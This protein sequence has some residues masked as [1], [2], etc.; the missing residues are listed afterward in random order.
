[1]VS[2]QE[3]CGSVFWITGLSNA[4]KSSIAIHLQKK[5]IAANRECILLDGDVIRHL[6]GSDLGYDNIYFPSER[7]KYKF[8][9]GEENNIGKAG[10]NTNKESREKILANFEESL[11]NGRIKTKSTRLVSELKTF[12]WNG[13]KVGAMKGYNDDLIMSL[14]IGCWLSDSNSDSYNTT[15][16]EYADALLKGMEVNNTNINKTNISP[17]YNSKETVVNPFIPTFMGEN[18]FSDNK[19]QSTKN[20]PLGDL[21]WLIGK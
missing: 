7:E 3:Y 1:M 8:L 17:F 11:R 10:F 15:Q 6:F 18:R 19:K 5:I 9:Y 14:A 2:K 21:S 12:V 20:N 13:K 4:G 16:M